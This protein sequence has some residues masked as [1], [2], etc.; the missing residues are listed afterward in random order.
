M[1][2]VSYCL[3]LVGSLQNQAENWAKKCPVKVYLVED[4]KEKNANKE[5]SAIFKIKSKV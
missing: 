1:K 5:V 3:P 4:G 2:N